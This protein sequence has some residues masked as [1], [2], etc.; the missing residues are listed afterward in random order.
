M[1]SNRTRKNSVLDAKTTTVA[2][3]SCR[4]TLPSPSDLLLS[5][6]K[7]SGSGALN[8]YLRLKLPRR[9]TSS[10]RASQLLKQKR[11]QQK[12]I[13]ARK[14]NR[15]Q[16]IKKCYSIMII[17]IINYTY[18]YTHKGFY[19]CTYADKSTTIS[20][21]TYYVCLR[22]SKQQATA[23]VVLCHSRQCVFQNLMADLMLLF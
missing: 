14:E 13:I 3:R 19:I 21:S 7:E 9:T 22:S 10:W 16:K 1:H 20:K 18:K 5:V 11:K 12:Q 17:I 23:V 15:G 4:T 8:I 6:C 2:I